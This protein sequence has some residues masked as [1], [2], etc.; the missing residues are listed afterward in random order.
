MI[1]EFKSISNV[2]LE[3]YNQKW[4]IFARRMLR[5]PKRS[6]EGPLIAE[7][8]AEMMNEAKIVSVDSKLIQ[9][10]SVYNSGF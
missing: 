5:M 7:L 2:D 10:Y 3:N 1:T 9:G 8:R 6:K 4:A